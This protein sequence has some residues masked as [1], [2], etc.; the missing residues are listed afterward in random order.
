MGTT[1]TWEHLATLEAA[2]ASG[3]RH[4]QYGDKS[5]TYQ[6]TA[7]MLDARAAILSALSG[8]TPKKLFAKHSKGL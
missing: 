1:W 5:V 6:T 3:N 7:Q 8:G 4:V 2:I